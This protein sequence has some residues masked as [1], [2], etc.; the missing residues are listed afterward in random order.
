MRFRLA[1]RDD[2]D[3]DLARL[4]SEHLVVIELPELAALVREPDDDPLTSRSGIE[5]AGIDDIA[6]TL[7][8][9]R[10]LPRELTV[11]VSLREGAASSG[12]LSDVETALHRRATHLASVAWREGMAVRSTGLAQLPVGLAIAFASGIL[13]YVLGYL[14]TQVDGGGAGLLAVTAIFAITVAWVVSWV[15]IEAAVLDW[16]P[17]ARQAVAYDLLSSARLEVTDRHGGSEVVREE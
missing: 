12:E 7:I 13:A 15:V 16:R 6:A 5:Q 3:A 4:R 9:A 2:L 17:S 14:A 8:A 10:R 1:A 11:R